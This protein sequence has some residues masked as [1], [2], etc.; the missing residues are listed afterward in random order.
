M[1]V[2]RWVMEV[3]RPTEVPR[4][5]YKEFKQVKIEGDNDG[6]KYDG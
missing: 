4:R 2:E 6:F 1:Y 5:I 3:H